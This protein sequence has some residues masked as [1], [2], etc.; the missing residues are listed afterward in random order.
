VALPTLVLAIFILFLVFATGRDRESAPAVVLLLS[1]LA[2]P[3]TMLANCWVLFVR[4]R[5][6]AL[7]FMAGLALPSYVG[8]AMAAYVHGSQYGDNVGMIMLMPFFMVGDGVARHPLAWF[9]IWAL[10]MIA[11]IL[12]ALALT[13][14]YEAAS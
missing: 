6:R 11:C 14:R 13:R 10:G 2:L 3:A 1:F 5:A 7:L 4:W 9:A 8:C 12:M